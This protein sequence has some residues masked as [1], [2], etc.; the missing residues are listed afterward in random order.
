MPVDNTLVLQAEVAAYVADIHSPVQDFLSC[1]PNERDPSV[2]PGFLHALDDLVT[3]LTSEVKGK[4]PLQVY[5][6]HTHGS[7]ALRDEVY[8]CHQ[9]FLQLPVANTSRATRTLRPEG[10]FV[11]DISPDAIKEYEDIGFTDKEI[12]G[13]LGCSR[14]TVIRR[15]NAAQPY[16]KRQAKHLVS[17]D[18]LRQAIKNHLN[19]LDGDMLGYRAVQGHLASIG[20]KVTRE[21][22]RALL[23]EINPASAALRRAV[24]RNRRVYKVPFPN[25]LWHI[26]GQH[27]LIRWKFVIHGGVDGYSRVCVFMKASDN[28][29]AETVEQ[30]FLTGTEE[31]GWPQRVRVD[32]GG[33]NMG[34]WKQMIAIRSQSSTGNM[35][36]LS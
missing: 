32:Y 28:N 20:M 16:T 4:L 26:D 8:A 34:I 9:G 24:V 17:E 5:L 1:E 6:D 18:D 33:E 11:L 15:R 36:T 21:Q 27:K 31:W 25:S 19:Q 10:G 13:F 35:S 2:V 7:I 29:R 30:L 23:R 14:S 3:W 22:V 12:A